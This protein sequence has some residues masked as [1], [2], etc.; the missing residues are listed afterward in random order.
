MT[1]E[2]LTKERNIFLVGFVVITVTSIVFK[3]I[4][5]ELSKNDLGYILN[6]ALFMTF[7]AKG[8][9]I[10]LTFRLS[11]FLKH[12]VWLTLLYCLLAPLPLLYLIPLVGLLFSVR[13]TRKSLMTT[14]A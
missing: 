9:I 6:V 10:Y 2:G 7:L 13:N 8:I 12:P 4:L 3:H 11:R 5:G 14:N 1:N